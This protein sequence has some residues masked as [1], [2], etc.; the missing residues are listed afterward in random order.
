MRN[1]LKLQTTALLGQIGLHLREIFLKNQ[2]LVVQKAL[3]EHTQFVMQSTIQDCPKDIPVNF[4]ALEFIPHSIW[5]RPS[6]AELD[7]ISTDVRDF[8][9][10]SWAY[11][12]AASHFFL[13]PSALCEG[14]LNFGPASH[15]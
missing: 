9:Y 10:D 14:R 3:L 12:E 15:T 1:L 6:L 2:Q 11:Q 4:F 7:G 13:D 5:P 8:A